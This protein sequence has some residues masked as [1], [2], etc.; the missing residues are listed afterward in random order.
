[1]W[2]KAQTE[3]Y[4]TRTV[5]PIAECRDADIPRADEPTPQLNLVLQSPTTPDQFD[6][7]QN[8]DVPR[9]GVHPHPWSS[10][11]VG[12]SIIT[13]GEFD[14]WKCSD[15]LRSDVHPTPW[16][17]NLVGQS[18]ITEGEFDMWKCSDVLRSDVHP[19]P[20]SSNLMVQS[21]TTPECRYTRMQIYPGQMSPL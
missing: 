6:M 21:P 5:F 3:P 7:W 18:I 10:N 20:W 13:A 2:R 19:T 9:P 14:M 15:V 12:Q 17:S 16:S 1:M 8:A 11:L 4:Y